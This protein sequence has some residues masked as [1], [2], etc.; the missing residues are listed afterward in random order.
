MKMKKQKS[1]FLATTMLILFVTFI[2]LSSSA[3][4]FE[5][6]VYE[7]DDTPAL[8]PFLYTGDPLGP[9]RH[10]FHDAGDE[11][12]VK[13]YALAGETYTVQ[14][15]NLG[16]RCD[17]VIEIYDADG[18]TLLLTIDDGAAGMKEIREWAPSAE[19]DYLGSYYLRVRGYDA[20]VFGEST[21]YDLQVFRPVGAPFGITRVRSDRP[22]VVVPADPKDWIELW[23]KTEIGQKIWTFIEVPSLFPGYRFARA[24]DAYR[25]QQGSGGYVFLYS[26]NGQLIPNAENL[27]FSGSSDVSFID[28]GRNDFFRALEGRS[29]VKI[30]VEKGEIGN[31]VPIQTILIRKEEPG[32]NQDFWDRDNRG[33][34]D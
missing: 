3:F 25:A 14:A 7:D 29:D 23:C 27:Y 31:T 16:S 34:A 17:L 15:S 30:I 5:A 10:N 2:F 18:T 21:E 13:F 28:F 12:W 32:S 20:T 24:S 8:A 4:A 22:D 33:G 1:P 19:N 6:D 26:A 11:D 9:Q